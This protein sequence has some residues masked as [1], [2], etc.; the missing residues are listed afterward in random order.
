MFGGRMLHFLKDWWKFIQIHQFYTM[1]LMCT[2]QMGIS[3][4]G[5][6]SNI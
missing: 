4:I 2:K 6:V 5:I 3:Q 1:A